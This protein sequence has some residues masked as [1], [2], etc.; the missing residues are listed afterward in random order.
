MGDGIDLGGDWAGSLPP[1][2]LQRLA[3]DVV[4][5]VDDV[6]RWA[7]HAT[8]GRM[9]IDP[10]IEPGTLLLLVSALYCACEW[11]R[12]F[13]ESLFMRLSGR[14]ATLARI[15]ALVRVDPDVD[16]VWSHDV[17]AGV[18]VT[19]LDVRGSAGLVV[20][21][22]IG[23][24][25]APPGEVLTSA[26]DGLSST[27]RTMG[28]G[29]AIGFESPGLRVYDTHSSSTAQPSVVVELPPFEIASKHDLLAMS[30]AVGLEASSD[31]SR[32]H[33]YSSRGLELVDLV[34]VVDGVSC[35]FVRARSGTFYSD[36]DRRNSCE[37]GHTS[38]F[39]HFRSMIWCRPVRLVRWPCRRGAG[40]RAGRG[41]DVAGA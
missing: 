35:R 21:C 11:E 20:T 38:R 26:L 27:E 33:R 4:Q 39:P 25:H 30:H 18:R 7:S 37:R 17:G 32:G 9:S 34:A 13:D 16:T 19:A 40:W 2:T 22:V 8:R 15:P 29:M 10:A 28:S 31:P 41:S 5:A 12:P 24:E 1:R 14:W 36:I 23:G 3:G 6:R